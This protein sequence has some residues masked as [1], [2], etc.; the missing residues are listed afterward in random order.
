MTS[1]NS[2]ARYAFKPGRFSSH[3]RILGLADGWPRSARILEIGTASGYLG[4]ELRRLGF[5]NVAGVECDPAAADEARAHY[6][7]FAVADLEQLAL[8]DE[9]QGFDV[10]ICADVLEHLRDPPAQLRQLT[11]LLKPTARLVV[12]LP[13]V[14][15]LTVRLSLLAGRFTYRDR[16]LLDRTHLRFFTRRTARALIED[17]GYVIERCEPTPIP[18]AFLLAGLAPATLARWAETAYV[19]LALA[20]SA[21]FAYQFVFV[22]RTARTAPISPAAR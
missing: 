11:R 17:A 10:L 12:S 9:F 21:L 2:A 6:Q 7:S 22:A 1:E 18:I 4:R 14:A 16:G 5:M 15:N 19:A 3:G 20:W 8:P 13:N